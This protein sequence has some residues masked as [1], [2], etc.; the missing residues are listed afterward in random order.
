M[1]TFLIIVFVIIFLIVILGIIYI[2]L[3]NK[4]SESI[5]RIDEAESRIDNDL[6]DK[7]DLLQKGTSLIRSKIELDDDTFKD[8]IKLKS[9]KLSN[10][11]FDRMLVKIT[12]EYS[13]IYDNNQELKENEEINKTSKQIEIIDAELVTLRNY[14]NANVVNYNSMIKKIPTNIIAKIKKYKEKLFYDLKDM[15]DEDHEDFKI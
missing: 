8:L 13:T 2:N 5:I 14:Y 15:N 10:F 9:M 1:N 4:F 7:Y 11:E 12:N 6:R 3:Y